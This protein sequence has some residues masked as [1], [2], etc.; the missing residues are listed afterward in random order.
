MCSRKCVQ[1]PNK[2]LSVRSWAFK[3]P[4]SQIPQCTSPIS[5]QYTIFFHSGV[6]WDMGLVHCGIYETR[7]FKITV[8]LSS[9]WMIFQHIESKTNWPMF[10]GHLKCIFVNQN[11]LDEVYNAWNRHRKG[12]F[13]T[14]LSPNTVLVDAQQGPLLL[15]WI[16]FPQSQHG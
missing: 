7:I 6:L 11:A 16:N 4:V 8:K 15:T 2:A 13:H 14:N 12:P 10:Y 1:V 3:R 9:Q 5:R